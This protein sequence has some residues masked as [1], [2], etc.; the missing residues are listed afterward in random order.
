MFSDGYSIVPLLADLSHFVAQAE[1]SSPPLSLPPV[2]NPF[3]IFEHRL[4]R[5]IY[6]DDSSP[7]LVTP[8]SIRIYQN[9]IPVTIFLTIPAKIIMA[10]R[11]CARHL[12]VSDDIVVLTA[13]GVALAKLERQT[14]VPIELVVPQRDGFAESDIVGLFSDIRHISIHTE[15]LNFAG[16]ALE[17][18]HIVRERLWLKP[19]ISTQFSAAFVNFEWTDFQ[20]R[21][22]FCQVPQTSLRDERLLNPMKISIDQPEAETWRM[23]LIFDKK[24]YTSQQQNKFVEDLADGFRMLITAPLTPAWSELCGEVVDCIEPDIQCI[25]SV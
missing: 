13:I 5:T 21:H 3:A 20:A 24:L 2:P 23:R 22:G 7:D 16:V 17:L 18:N 11:R 8:E 19:G 9:H 14:S 6:A 10:L 12:G 15:G 25:A 4:A 1:G